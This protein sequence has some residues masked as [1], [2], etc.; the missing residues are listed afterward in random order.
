MFKGMNIKN[1]TEDQSNAIHASMDF[2]GSG[3]ISLPE[4][5]A[6]FNKTVHKDFATLLFELKQHVKI[7][8]A[9]ED[10]RDIDFSLAFGD[11]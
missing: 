5:Q 6:D 11:K 8:K 4:F 9:E 10:E 7:N 1:I 2:D 3:S